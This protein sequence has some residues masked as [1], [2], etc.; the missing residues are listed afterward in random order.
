[1]LRHTERRTGIALGIMLLQASVLHA[2][3]FEQWTA[4]GDAAFARQEF[5]GATRFYDGALAIDGGRLSVQW[6]QAE[7]CRLSH[8]YPKAAALYERVHKKDQG[9]THSLALRW[10][11]EMQMSMGDHAAAEATWRKVLQKEKDKGSVVAKRAE[12]AITGCALA[13]AVAESSPVILLEHLPQPLNTYDSEFGA[14]IGPEGMLYFSSLRGELNKEGE[15]K[16]T[17]AYR[18][19]LLRSATH[20]PFEPAP[21]AGAVNALH[22]NANAA[23]SRD[24][25]WFLF[26]RCGPSEGCR[27]HIAP[28]TADGFGEPRLLP[29]IGDTV[30]STQPMIAWWDER[31]MLLFATDRAGGQGG[32]DIW[33]A[34][35]HD[36]AVSHLY[37]LGRAINSPGNERCPWYDNRSN[38][39][40]FS[41]DFLP[42]FGGYDIFSAGWGND[43]FATPVNAESPI[44]S[45]ANDLYPMLDHARGEGWLTSNRIGSFAAKGE[46][47]CNDL[48]RWSLPAI[49][50]VT[51]IVSQEEGPTAPIR[52]MTATERLIAMQRDFPLVLYFHNDDPEPRSWKRTTAQPY[53]EAYLRYKGLQGEYESLTQD[54]VAVQRFFSE[55]VDHGYE[56]LQD[57]IS[58]LFPALTEGRSVTLDVRGHA[59]PLARTDYNRYL[60]MRRIESLRNALRQHDGGTLAPYLDGRAANGARLTVRELPFGEE[61]SAPDVSDDL[62]DTR[63]S[64]H[65][66]EAMRERRIEV[67][68][69]GL[70]HQES[71]REGV[72][73][74]QHVGQLTVGMERTVPFT[75]T[76]TGNRPLRLVKAEVDC[77]CT[78]A[79][80]PKAPLPPGGSAV[81]EVTFNGRAQPGALTRIVVVET[82]GEPFRFDLVLQGEV[83]P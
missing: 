25:R 74:S 69:I 30:Q 12:N 65:S 60:S 41:S 63:K 75:L 45:P 68:G 61:R 19:S 64:V 34:E 7:A 39:L 23:W 72:R 17:A 22:D 32:W 18:A 13:K 40:W 47:C 4:W 26:S 37:P 5:Y 24:G 54:S 78:T 59:S 76:N 58:G 28:V 3:S 2:Q 1:M 51:L 14:R 38:A 10:L 44:N 16:D 55:H 43:I 9:R 70:E 15:V 48:Y 82:D 50:T 31:E 81:V 62:L 29:G 20:P 8:Q 80:L 46:T 11:G 35:F 42:G 71:A 6:K 49:D 77:G 21:L 52:T 36:G 83:V 33:Q 57:L 66:V 67:V 56:R 79:A 73:I 27:I 53:S